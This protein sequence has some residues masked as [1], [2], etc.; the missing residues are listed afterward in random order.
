MIPD[1]EAFH[2]AIKVGLAHVQNQ[3]IVTFGIKPTHP[4]TG[5][6]YLETS[7]HPV[8]EYG[9]SDLKAF[10]EKPKVQDAE[11]MVEAGH[12]LWNA[13][14]FLFR[15]Q[16]MIDAF[17]TY[18]SET[19][20]LVSQAVEDALPDLGFLRLAKEPWSELQ[21]ISIDYAIMEKAEI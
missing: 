6:G 3:K 5:Y 21:D 11:Q 13:G 14:I 15:A 8:D 12:Y 20:D 9:A 19:L 4:E 10:I 16:D 2:K 17:R 1:T 7:T 18:A